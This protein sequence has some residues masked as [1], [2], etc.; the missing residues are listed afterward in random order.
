MR[1]HRLAA[2]AALVLAAAACGG[3]RRADTLVMPTPT[4]TPAPATVVTRAVSGIVVSTS[5]Q[6]IGGARLTA[7][8]GGMVV[9][10]VSDA[11]GAFA[12]EYPAIVLPQ[13]ATVTAEGYEGHDVG[14]AS[15]TDPV[16]VRVV[17]QP[18][19]VLEHAA[20]AEVSLSDNDLGYYVGEPYE[21]AYCGPCV[22]VR[23][24]EDRPTV[25]Q[26]LTGDRRLRMWDAH[27]GESV[28]AGDALVVRSTGLVY[29]GLPLES[30]R[31]ATLGAPVAVRLVVD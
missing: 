13:T 8:R 27:E 19:I 2:T 10:A 22:L 14:W 3:G 30:S 12:F 16:T 31:R 1:I 25:V 21:S 9:D 28:A 4:S 6:P 5:G 29:V 23:I 26:L 18:R 20:T 15:G 17:M 24:P 11:T 7:G